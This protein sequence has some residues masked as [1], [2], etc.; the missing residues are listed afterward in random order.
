[1]NGQ[2]SSEIFPIYNQKNKELLLY[3]VRPRVLEVVR[4]DSTYQVTSNYKNESE[5]LKN[6]IFP[7]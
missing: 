2:A 6:D 7:R 1:M 5:I 4:F 3:T